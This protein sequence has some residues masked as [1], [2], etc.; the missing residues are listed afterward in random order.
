MSTKLAGKG[1]DA[2][3]LPVLVILLAGVIECSGSVGGGEAG[4]RRK[5]FGKG[6]RE[7]GR[8]VGQR[9]GRREGV[10]SRGWRTG[11]PVCAS[12]TERGR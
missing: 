8:G 3:E 6:K 5:G 2:L 7:K 4:R 9:L 1:K 12:P 10:N 11:F